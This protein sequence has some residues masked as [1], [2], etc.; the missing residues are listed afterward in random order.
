M[1]N[2]DQGASFAIGRAQLGAGL[3]ACG[4]TGSGSPDSVG[5]TE[6]PSGTFTNVGYDRR[7]PEYE[8]REGEIEIIQWAT[9]EGGPEQQNLSANSG[10]VN[11]VV[12]EEKYFSGAIDK[13]SEFTVYPARGDPVFSL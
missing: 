9:D 1:R 11:A 10:L 8:R 5:K 2:P 4:G 12:A 6:L 3:A 7:L 13:S